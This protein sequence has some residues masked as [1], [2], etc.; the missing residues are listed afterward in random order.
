MN[1]Y[2]VL[3]VYTALEGCTDPT[4]QQHKVYTR[5]YP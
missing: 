3:G 4:A 2:P 5:G 1:V